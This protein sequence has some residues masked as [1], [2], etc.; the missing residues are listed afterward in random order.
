MPDGSRRVAGA[1]LAAFAAARVPEAIR[2]FRPGPLPPGVLLPAIVLLGATLALIA[3]LVWLGALWHGTPARYF[4]EREPATHASGAL[5]F[6][7][8]AVAVLVARRAGVPSSRRFWSLA[9]VGFAFLALDDL[10]TIHED[11]DR[12]I[13]ALLGW[14]SRH[15]LTDHLDDAIVAAYGLVAVAWAYR[16]RADILRLRWTALLLGVAFAGFAAMTAIDFAAQRPEIE[17]SLKLLAEAL[18]VI[19][20]LAA[21][22]DPALREPPGGRLPR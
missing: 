10:L 16:H 9:A 15:W 2:R 11:L 8:A 21:L 17:E 12:A 18:I 7:A 1:G 6:A 22:R 14:D 5:L 4:R 3:L 20:L 13:H 19:G